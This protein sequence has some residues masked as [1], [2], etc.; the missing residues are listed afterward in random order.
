M[1]CLLYFFLL[2]LGFHKLFTEFTTNNDAIDNRHYKQ[3]S[4]IRKH[5]NEALRNCS[6]FSYIHCLRS[7]YV[8][9]PR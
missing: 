2:H 8:P 7:S 5:Q 4:N 9:H 6:R 1:L 3:T